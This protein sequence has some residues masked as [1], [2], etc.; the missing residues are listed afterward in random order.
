VEYGLAGDLQ[1]LLGYDQWKNFFQAISR[2]K[3]ACESSVHEVSDH[4][5]DVSKNG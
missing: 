5:T 4:F 2:A 3:I 1:S